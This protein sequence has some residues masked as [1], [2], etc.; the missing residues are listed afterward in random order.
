VGAEQGRASR[1]VEVYVR[2][3]P[4]GFRLAYLLTGDRAR[5]EDLVQGPLL[6]LVAACTTCGTPRLSTLCSLEAVLV[7]VDQRHR[8]V[9]TTRD[10]S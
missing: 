10:R 8:A 2:S 5:A 7:H 9:A 1:L 3:A 6:R 4:A